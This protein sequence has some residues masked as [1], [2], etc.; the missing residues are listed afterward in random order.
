MLRTI[1]MLK[2]FSEEIYWVSKKT[3][4]L[5]FVLNVPTF[6]VKIKY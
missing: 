3:A 2:Q 4:P 5:I 6:V 1:I